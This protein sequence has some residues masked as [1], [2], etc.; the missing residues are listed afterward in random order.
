LALFR[1]LVRRHGKARQIPAGR[2]PKPS[3]SILPGV[4]GRI[5][6]SMMTPASAL[7]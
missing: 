3:P 7:S 1:A 5:Q 2:R 6:I 4:S